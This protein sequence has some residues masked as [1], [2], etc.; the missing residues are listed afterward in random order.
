MQPLQ[1]SVF[2]LTRMKPIK[3]LTTQ[4]PTQ[5]SYPNIPPNKHNMH[6]IK[7]PIELQRHNTIINQEII[8][9]TINKHKK[10]FNNIQ[11]NKKSTFMKRK[12]KKTSDDRDIYLD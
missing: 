4:N 8:N 3:I 6:F 11:Q 12:K 1:K 7:L 9:N 2:V 5:Q 10:T